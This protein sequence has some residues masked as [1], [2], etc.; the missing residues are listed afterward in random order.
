M[1][2][3]LEMG[4]LDGVIFTCA[5]H[6]AQFDVTSGEALLGPVPT[7]LDGDTAPPRTAAFLKNTDM[8]MQHI[9]TQSIHTR[10]KLNRGGFWS[11][12]KGKGKFIHDADGQ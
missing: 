10:R 3:L 5:M 9:R 4:T 6:C 1:N 11:Q 8:L 12:F 2:A 7:Y